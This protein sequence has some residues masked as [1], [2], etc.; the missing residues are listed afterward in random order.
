MDIS[1]KGVLVKK[2]VG[3]QADRGERTDIS[4][5]LNDQETLIHMLGRVAHTGTAQVGFICYE[6][7]ME[8]ISHLRRLLELNLGDSD[9]LERDL[10]A[11]G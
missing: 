6:I 4:V 9:L 3:W 10:K 5:T 1:L 11:L 7:D 8:S 2:P